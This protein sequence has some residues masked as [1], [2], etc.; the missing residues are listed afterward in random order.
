MTTEAA[1]K[2][3]TWLTKWLQ[4]LR[5]PPDLTVSEWAD[6]FRML[7]PES[8][9]EPGRW[10]TDRAPYQREI[11]DVIGDPTVERVVVMTSSQV[12][13]TEIVNNAVGYFVHLAPGPMMVVQPTLDMARTWS[14]DRLEP[15]RR[16]TPVLEERIAQGRTKAGRAT[17]LHKTFPG[18][19][20]TVVGANAPAA[21]ASRPIGKLFLDEVDRFPLSAGKEGDPVALAERRTTTF[22]DRT[23]LMVSTPTTAGISRIYK[24][25][26]DSDQRLYEVPCPLCGA[27]Q[28]LVWERLERDQR[29][30]RLPGGV[31]WEGED[32]DLAPSSAWYECAHCEGRIEPHHKRDMV[33]SGRW[34]AT[35]PGSKTPGFFLNALISPWMDWSEVVAAYLRA[36]D[37]PPQ[38]QVFHNTLLGQIWDDGESVDHE[39]LQRLAE[40]YQTPPESVL[41]LSA[42]VDV[43]GDRLEALLVGWGP[44]DE[45]WC[46]EHK[47]IF[48][49]PEDVEDP[50][51]RELERW[52]TAP[53]IRAD[54]QRLFVQIMM[55]DS[56]YF[57]DAV[58]AYCLPRYGQRVFA[59]KGVDG[60][61]KPVVVRRARRKKEPTKCPVFTVGAD[62]GKDLVFARLKKREPGPGRIHF[63]NHFSAEFFA[64]VTSEVRQTTAESGRWRVRYVQRRERNEALDLL[65]LNLAG[66]HLDRPMLVGAVTTPP[67]PQVE[68]F[69]SERPAEQSER[70]PGIVPG[71]RLSR[72]EKRRRWL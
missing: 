31:R 20:L 36:K 25:W 51:W 21:L 45:S 6:R 41:Y 67:E 5:P 56:G 44:G 39:M 68:L 57:T 58:Y 26:E 54:G 15:M 69:A 16:D 53:R 49:S 33:S 18:G 40:P 52:R 19:H 47:V 63:P 28:P 7:S 30:R 22:H 32:P 9:A 71:Q 55:V 4:V 42:G 3:A 11:M 8:S 34:S 2:A 43:Q 12:G 35:N 66:L 72:P 1:R 50:C 62:V 46:L 24:A 70:A 14:G 59:T 23:I 29:N 38:L 64:Q 65:V 61:D 37:D 17:K 10:A 60:F 48:G 27:F 13:K